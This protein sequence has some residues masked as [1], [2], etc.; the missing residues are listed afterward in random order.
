[1]SSSKFRIIASSLLSASLLIGLGSS[2][3]AQDKAPKEEVAEQKAETLKIDPV[4]SSVVFRVKHKEAAYVFGQFY[5]KSGEVKYDPNTPENLSFTVEIVTDSVATGNTKRDTHL[6]SADFFDAKQYPKMTF[7]STSAKKRGENTYEVTGDLSIH[8]KTQQVTTIVQMTG[9]S[10]D[11]KGNL[12][13][14]F[15][16]TLNI[17]RSDFGMDFMI[18]PVSDNVKLVLSIEGVVEAK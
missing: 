1:M 8:G 6:K 5:G 18:G 10:V 16:T 9:S 7:K 12:A 3:I 14:G 13:R 4:H 15:Y 11:P 17:N 2:A